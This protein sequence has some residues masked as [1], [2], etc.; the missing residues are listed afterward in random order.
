MKTKKMNLIKVLAL[1]GMLLNMI[2]QAQA[3]DFSFGEVKLQGKGCKDGTTSVV[4]SPDNQALSILFDEFMVEVPQYNGDNDNGDS[5]ETSSRSRSRFNE[6]LDHKVCNIV[7]EANVKD[8]EMVKSVEVTSDFRGGLILE[9]DAQ[10]KFKST[11]MSWV[12]PQRGR[13]DRA[14]NVIVEKVWKSVPYDNDWD[15]SNNIRI[16]INTHCSRNGDRKTILRIK[17]QIMARLG[18]ETGRND[19]MA[20]LTLD[21]ADFAGKM[22]FKVHT[23]KCQNGPTTRPTTTPRRP[24]VDH[25]RTPTCRRGM[26]FDRRRGRC[27]T[28]RRS[29]PSPRRRAPAP[30]RSSRRR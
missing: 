13:R 26:T 15:A 20:F 8:G 6:R 11:L 29:A 27:V 12:G 10:A 25:G 30:R 7:I 2:P 28:S 19:G 18:R 5:G 1:S 24:R 22:K 4:K 21:S 9:G 16:P 23:A 14:N 17:N 3:A